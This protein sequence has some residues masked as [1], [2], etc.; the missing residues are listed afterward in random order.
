[1]A[2]PARTSW[3]YLKATWHSFE[4][5]L[6]NGEA[7]L[8]EFNGEGVEPLITRCSLAAFIGGEMNALVA[9][10]MYADVLPAALESARGLTKRKKFLGLF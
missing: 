4:L 6:G 9:S 1:M 10:S 3:T 2:E 8:K 7:I 5:R